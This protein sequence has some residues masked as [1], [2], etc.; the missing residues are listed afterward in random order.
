[1][2][3][4]SQI[5]LILHGPI[6]EIARTLSLEIDNDDHFFSEIEFFVL[7][8]LKRMD[9]EIGMRQIGLDKA[10]FGIEDAEERHW[11]DMATHNERF[12]D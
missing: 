9:K 5:G 3:Q 7:E 2:E 8:N 4:L 1:M 11:D 12:C 6:E 10:R